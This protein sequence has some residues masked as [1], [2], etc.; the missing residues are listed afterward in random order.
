MN[1]FD[2]L[3]P[4]FLKR[5]DKH[6]LLNHRLIWETKFH[7]VLFYGIIGVF[8]AL[9]IGTFYPISTARS[10]PE[11]EVFALLSGIPAFILLA[12]WIYKQYL[13][14][15]EQNY[16]SLN[17]FMGQKRLL[18]YVC[19]AILFAAPSIM[20]PFLIHNR[21]GNLAS[22]DELNADREILNAGN[23]FFPVPSRYQYESDNIHSY[24]D[25]AYNNEYRDDYCD[26]GQIFTRF[27]RV[28]T[29]LSYMTAEQLHNRFVKKMNKEDALKKIE[30]FIRV[31]KKYGA[32]I[33]MTPEEV[34]ANFKDEKELSQSRVD[35]M[36]YQITRQLW[37]I[38]AH[39]YPLVAS[40]DRY[41]FW[42][43][44]LTCVCFFGI[45]IQLVK[46]VSLRDLI[47]SVVS[48]IGLAIGT[49]VLTIM[50]FEFRAIV[51]IREEEFASFFVLSLYAFTLYQAAGI[52]MLKTYSRFKTVMLAMANIATP[53]LIFWLA[54][55]GDVWDVFDLSPKSDTMLTNLVLSGFAV[56]GLFFF[57]WFRKLHLRMH[58]LPRG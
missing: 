2:R 9:F 4:N 26:K 34:L 15:I 36:K 20:L 57:P 16:G 12:F 42:G 17:K 28:E 56:Y 32:T 48:I 41:T 39:Q 5:L 51:S 40:S 25:C 18:I 37:D 53:F 11:P 58:S 8:A 27:G 38:E 23:P 29:P 47:I 21:I 33:R 3:T 22:F 24:F 50:V 35:Q 43:V 7:F 45:L 52:S 54:F 49:T 31:S 1:F 30:E 13:H 10:I 55:T 6:L 14:T 44:I 19:S 46:S